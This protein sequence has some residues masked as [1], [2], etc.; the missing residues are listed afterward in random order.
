MEGRKVNVFV[1]LYYLR[2][3]LRN[4][5]DVDGDGKTEDL[6]VLED[7]F[8]VIRWYMDSFEKMFAE[9]GF[10]N[11]R[12]AGYYWYHE[13][14]PGVSEDPDARAY[15]TG[16]AKIAHERGS[17][18][19]WIPYYNSQGYT[20]WAQFGLDAACLQPNYAFNAEV[21]EKRL[22]SA[23]S[24]AKS[25]GLCLEIE[26][27]DKAFTSHTFFQKYMDYMKHGVIDGYMT[28]TI[29]MYYQ[30]GSIFRRAWESSSGKLRL[31]YDYTYQFIK[32]TLNAM[33]GALEDVSAEGTKDTPLAGKLA[34]VDDAF[35]TYRLLKGPAHG[36][37]TVN[38]DG[39]F[40]Y[41]PDKGYT[42]SDSFTYV[43]SA[44]V[45][46][47]EPCLCKVEMK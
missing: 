36:T 16:T 35:V 30:S 22:P 28:E 13:T 7:R 4:F 45:G 40:T 32:G 24:I 26:I 27:D 15:I 6:S 3:E 42:G 38:E 43:Y 34:Q 41:Y 14:I 8:K 33:P 1:S 29:H 47:S 12:F 17:Q 37:V 20:D 25:L 39:S 11:L 19:F 23:A 31:I 2:P 21:L 44:Y 46:D 5:G 10:E 9:A 18:L